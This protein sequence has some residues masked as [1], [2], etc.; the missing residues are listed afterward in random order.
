[1]TNLKRM[2][3]DTM[4]SWNRSTAPAYNL[5]VHN[6][7]NRELQDKV[8]ELMDCEGFYDEINYMINDFDR[9]NDYE[10]QVGFNGRSGGY[11]VLYR[12]GKKTKHLTK[13]DFKSNNGYNGQVYISDR[14]GWKNYE[15]AKKLNL[16]DREII[17]GIFTQP[18]KNIED[19]E[20]PGKVLRAF[21]TLAVNIVKHVEYMAKN[22]SVDNEEYTVTKTR[23]VINF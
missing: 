21:R 8:F 12:G 4:N 1:M 18:G 13:E 11:L 9:E 7:I 5:K 20:V 6:V 14:Y 10:W 3:Y 16:V 2:R 23:K 15:E 22:A 19:N 17:T